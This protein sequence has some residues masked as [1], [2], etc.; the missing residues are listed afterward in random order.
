MEFSTQWNTHLIGYTVP[1][2][3]AAARRAHDLGFETIWLNDNVRY[4]NIFTVLTAIA[5]QVP[6]K[7]ATATIVPYFHNPITLACTLASLSDVC[8]GR[9]VRVGIAIGD[10]GQTPP[11]V[12][13]TKRLSMLR[14]STLFLKQALSG[15]TAF[16]RDFPTLVRY[17]RLNPEG[18]LK[19]AFAPAGPLPFYGGTLGPKSLAIA[20]EHMEGIVFPGQFLAFFKTG[21]LQRMVQIAKD[22]AASSAGKKALRFSALL[23]V[24]VSKDRKSARRFALPQVAH[25]VVS[26]KVA[27]LTQQEF[28]KVGIDPG[29]LDRLQEAFTRGG[30]ITIEE[31]SQMVDDRMIDAYY[32]AGTPEEVVPPL[33]NLVRELGELGIEEIAF[34]KLGYDYVDALELIAKEVIPHL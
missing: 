34:S 10:L 28:E 7:V 31:A 24:S 22:A 4:R 27:G 20:G 2:F 12:E 26:L 30:G 16:F 33:I 11:Y 8:Q 15:E 6:I 29:R 23:N 25:S 9:E 1:E 17:F 32:L 3:V 19:L 14:E 5:A 13:F 18:K 21:R